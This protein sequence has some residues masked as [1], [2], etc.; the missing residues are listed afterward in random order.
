MR[1]LKPAVELRPRIV[2]PP[3]RPLSIVAREFA[4]TVKQTVAD[5]VPT[6]PLLAP[7]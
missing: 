2:F 3:D 5:L 7:I 1:P 4:E 6:S